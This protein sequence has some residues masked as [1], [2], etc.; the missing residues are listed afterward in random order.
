MSKEAVVLPLQKCV[1]D[2]SQEQM[3]YI[4]HVTAIL[5]MDVIDIIAIMYII[6][7]I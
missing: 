4:S 6:D 7:I 2:H 1:H 3:L 5:L